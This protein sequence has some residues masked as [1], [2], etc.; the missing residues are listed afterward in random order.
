MKQWNVQSEERQ[1]RIA[2]GSLFAS[3]N[4]VDSNRPAEFLKGTP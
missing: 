1:R 3:G 4:A 2:A